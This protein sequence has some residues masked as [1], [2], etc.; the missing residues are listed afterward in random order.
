[1]SE[2]WKV[3][4]KIPGIQV[5]RVVQIVMAYLLYSAWGLV[6]FIIILYQ[7]ISKN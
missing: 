4:V 6:S 7:L 5:I 3:D 1:M 2:K